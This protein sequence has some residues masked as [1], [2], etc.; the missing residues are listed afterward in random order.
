MEI[1]SMDNTQDINFPMPPSNTPSR[2]PMFME[3]A[4]TTDGKQV[5]VE[6]IPPQKTSNTLGANFS[7]LVGNNVTV[8]TGPLAT[9]NTEKKKAKRKKSSDE[10][11]VETVADGNPVASP[12][13][14]DIVENT[15]YADTYSTT[16][17]MTYK[18]IGQTDELLRDAKQDLDFIRSQRNMKGKYHYTNAVLAS[19]S[20]LLSTKLAAIKE[21][22]S[23]IKSSNDAE[24]RRFKD[25]RAANAMDDN[26][27]IMDAYTAFISAPVGAPEYHQPGTM[28]LTGGL[29]GIIRADYPP[30]VQKSMDVGMANYL[31]NLT[32]EETLMLADNGEYEEVILYDEA[33]G[34]RQF[35]WIN[36]RTG[37]YVDSMPPSSSLT[38]S[39]YTIDTRTKTA[40]NS[41][42]N[43][44]KKVIV[45]NDG[46]MNKF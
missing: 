8:P 3:Q 2:Q 42:I 22:N 9:I 1:T 19:M 28:N 46:A 35:K 7:G 39:D 17:A 37:Q 11:A 40:R 30:E 23:T 25:L 14:N 26:K 24:Y 18:I 13:S 34:A 29:N 12:D 33:T 16:N 38:L 6:V 27:A 5:A 45:V 36:T 10:N 15:I 41:N 44:V 21:I 43:D 4:Y 31:S 32:P 20:S